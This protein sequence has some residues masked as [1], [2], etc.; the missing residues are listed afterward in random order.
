MIH[1]PIQRGGTGGPDPLEISQKYSNSGPDPLKITKLPSQHSIKGHNWYA[2]ETPFTFTWRFAGGPMMACL[3]WK[4]NPPS[5]HR[6]KR[7]QSWTPSDK[8]LWIRA[9]DSNI[10]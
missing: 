5:P 4:L 2:S 1:A 6:K 9:C 7:C 10:Q 3:L 8:I